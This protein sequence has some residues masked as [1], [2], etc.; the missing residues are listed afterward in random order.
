[1]CY[2]DYL[3]FWLFKLCANLCYLA[4]ITT[5]LNLQVSYEY[6]MVLVILKI[7]INSSYLQWRFICDKFTVSDILKTHV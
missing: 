5:S 7:L 2:V 3:K 1:M 4:I 6:H